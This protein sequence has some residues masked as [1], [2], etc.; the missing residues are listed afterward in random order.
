MASGGSIPPRGTMADVAAAAEGRA[1]ADVAAIAAVAGAADHGD[2]S[3]ERALRPASK[4]QYKNL[5]P[6]RSATSVAEYVCA[7]KVRLHGR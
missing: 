6:L 7:V 1:V 4:Q 5:R 2:S 3:V